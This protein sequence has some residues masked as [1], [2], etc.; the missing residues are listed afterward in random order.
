MSQINTIANSLTGNQSAG[1][2]IKD[3]D[4]DSFLK[5]MIAELQN[6]DPLNPMEND[7][8]LAQIGQMRE[9]AAS[10]KLSETLD[11]V[12]LGQNISSATNL[13]GAEIDAL[14]DDNQKVTGTVDKISIADG[15]PKLHIDER[16]G[17]A[18]STD[19]GDMAAGEYRYRIVWEASDGTLL[20]IETAKPIE[21]AED[22][23]SAVLANLPETSKAKQIYRTKAGSEGPYYLVGTLN[24]GK[25]AGF[26]DKT[27]DEDLSSS[28]LSRTPRWVLN[29][30][31][32][33]TVSLN[34]V[35]EIRPPVTPTTP[36][37]NNNSTNNT[38]TS[39]T[40]NN[41]SQ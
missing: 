20:G 5:L 17:A 40:N 31:R 29:A 36:T 27:A 13:I 33:Y 12:L 32:T 28:V 1:N 4:V 11:S 10:D 14:S 39:T 34:N 35:G 22:G 26:H 25:T 15:L 37:E 41:T 2:A 19:S 38:N 6:Q 18:A 3:L 23:Q 21:V 30:G 24:S 8:M 7:Q 16:A 9:I